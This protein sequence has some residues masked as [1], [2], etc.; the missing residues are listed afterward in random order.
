MTLKDAYR[1]TPASAAE[2]AQMLAMIREDT[3]QGIKPTR[4]E[5]H[6]DPL[7]VGNVNG[8]T[9]YLRARLR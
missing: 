7:T 6:V 4:V 9:A 2:A 1:K 5:L 8:R 3:R